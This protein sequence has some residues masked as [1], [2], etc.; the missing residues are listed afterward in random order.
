MQRC[1]HDQANDHKA[2]G[3]LRF[4]PEIDAQAS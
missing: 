2:Q 4:R 3:F 1:S